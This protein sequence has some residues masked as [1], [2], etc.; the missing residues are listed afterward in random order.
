LFVVLFDWIATESSRKNSKE[1][2]LLG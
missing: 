1:S 2:D